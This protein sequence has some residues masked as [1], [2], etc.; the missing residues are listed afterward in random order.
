MLGAIRRDEAFRAWFVWLLLGVNLAVVAMAL[1]GFAAVRRHEPVGGEALLLAGWAGAALYLAFG[2]VRTRGGLLQLALPIPARRL[3]TRHVLA[4]ALMAA[5][6]AAFGVGLGLAQL[7]ALGFAGGRGP[8][9]AGVVARLLG[10]VALAAVLLQLPGRGLMHTPVS[11]RYAAWA[12]SV[13][14]GVPLLLLALAPL[15]PAGGLIPLALALAAASWM[16]RGLPAVFVLAPRE[17]APGG[18]RAGERTAAAETGPARWI[19]ARSVAAG[20]SGGALDWMAYPFLFLFSMIAGGAMAGIADVAELGYAYLP[21]T[22]YMLF[23][24]SAPRLSRLHHLDP[25]PLPRRLLFATLVLPYLAAAVLGYGAGAAVNS[26][27]AK[28]R[29]AVDYVKTQDGHLLITPPSTR[30]IAWDGRVPK[31]TAPWG[32]AHVPEAVPLW[33]GS[34]AVLYSPFRGTADA[35]PEFAAWQLSRAVK[36]VYGADIPA[37]EIAERYFAADSAGRPAPRGGSLGLR[38]DFPGLERRGGGPLPAFFLILV[39]APW[40]FGMAGLRAYRADAPGWARHAI[41][42]GAAGAVMGGFLLM[43]MSWMAEF[44]QPWLAMVLVEVP[45]RKIGESVPATLAVW[46]A[47][48]ASLAVG[49]L[50][51]WRQFERMEIPARPPKYTLIDHMRDDT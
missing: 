21:L 42:Y 10:G 34:R 36:E 35:S 2:R 47:A 5:V 6:V 37:R 8:D 1:A 27:F 38:A 12:A 14:A 24:M 3:W 41:L 50:L 39:V 31:L 29:E 25:L 7:Q 46:G 40:L 9:V 17:A 33:R 49:G 11:W 26:H 22:A 32:E 20:V 19:V 43:V 28:S 48:G 44:T 23:A 4:V 30:E 18:P 13:L 16:A 15:G 45:A 51:A